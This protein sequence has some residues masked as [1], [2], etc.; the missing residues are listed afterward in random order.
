MKKLTNDS[1]VLASVARLGYQV[2]EAKRPNQT[3]IIMILSM[4][5]YASAEHSC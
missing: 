1:G 2:H 4:L 5:K 3:V